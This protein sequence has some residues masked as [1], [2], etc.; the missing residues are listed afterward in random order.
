MGQEPNKPNPTKS[1]NQSILIFNISFKQ[2]NKQT[3][4]TYKTIFKT[5]ENKKVTK[6]SSHKQ[7]FAL[8]KKVDK[9]I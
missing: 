5:K 7:S 2:T 3:R 8:Y 4:N 6:K 1:T 9:K